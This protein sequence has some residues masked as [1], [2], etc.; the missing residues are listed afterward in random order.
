MQMYYCMNSSATG[1][2][3]YVSKYN[4]VMYSCSL[5]KLDFSVIFFYSRVN[6]ELIRRNA[7]KSDFV[8]GKK[9]SMEVYLFDF[10]LAEGVLR[11]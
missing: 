2:I 4:V 3:V 9:R 7:V 11:D 6:S 1:A 10:S 5:C 8:S